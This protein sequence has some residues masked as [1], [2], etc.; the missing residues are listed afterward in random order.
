MRWYDKV[1]A[2][3]TAVT[4]TVSH[5]GRLKSDRYF[6]WQQDGV[7]D[8][9]ADGRHAERA[10]TG[11]TDLYTKREFDPW[12]AAFERQLDTTPGVAWQQLGV[13]WE[14]ETGFWHTE[15]EWEV[16]DDGTV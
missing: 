11:T 10:V 7:N 2:M 14:E 16:L 13:T 1:I 12:A 9:V 4:P 5:G 3:H 15:W 8:F 6:V